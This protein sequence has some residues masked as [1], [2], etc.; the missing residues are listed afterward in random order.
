MPKQT[1]MRRNV[2]VQFL[3]FMTSPED[4]KITSNF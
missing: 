4:N 2:H 1:Q 3:P